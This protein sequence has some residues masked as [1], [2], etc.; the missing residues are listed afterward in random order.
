MNVISWIVFGA[1]VGVL[2]NLLDPR[3]AVGGAIGAVVLGVLGAVVGGFLANVLLGISVTGFNFS[4]F[5]IAVLGSL[6]LL[7]IGRSFRGSNV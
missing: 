6:L 7:L 5:I 3:P 1:I 4:S 2:A